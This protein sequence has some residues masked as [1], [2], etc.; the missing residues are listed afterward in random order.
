MPTS[1][2][3]K[4]TPISVRVSAQER[5][6]LEKAA[7]QRPLSDYLRERLLSEVAPSRSGSGRKADAR[8]LGLLLAALGQSEIGPSLREL[9]ATVQLG[10][11]PTSPELEVTIRAACDAVLDMRRS[12]MQALG[13]IEGG[14]S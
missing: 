12:L 6:H 4:S 2:E 5:H 11:V 8:Q 1:I 7:G 13:L 3:P 9:L 14:S 10:L